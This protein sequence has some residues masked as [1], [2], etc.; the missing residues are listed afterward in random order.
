MADTRDGGA[1]AKRI[2]F[3]DDIFYLNLLIR[4]L[5]DGLELDLDAELFLTR[6]LDEFVFI[7]NSFETLLSELTENE[8]LIE[9]GEQLL[10]LLEAEERYAEALGRVLSARGTIAQGLQPF[11]QR[12]AE[13]R[14]KSMRRSSEINGATAFSS[15]GNDDADLVSPFELNELLKD[16]D[17]E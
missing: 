11:T 7:D 8:R 15:D 12:M 14:S 6:C 3:E 9:R 2:H 10:N 16:P 5:R 1:M 4:T 13:L 17:P